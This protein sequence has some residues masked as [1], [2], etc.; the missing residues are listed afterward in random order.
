MK[1]NP[2][3]LKP[4]PPNSGPRNG[5]VQA[6][7][8]TCAIEATGTKRRIIRFT[9]PLYRFFEK[10]AGWSPPLRNGLM[11]E[12]EINVLNDKLTARDT[13]AATGI[14]LRDQSAR[15]PDERELP[16]L[17]RWAEP[18]PGCKRSEKWTGH[19]CIGRRR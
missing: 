16:R 13:W 1:R 17:T 4:L 12:V 11:M 18:V 10:E 7:H 6:K 9:T 19:Q 5:I 8:P 2:F 14:L 15:R 3:D